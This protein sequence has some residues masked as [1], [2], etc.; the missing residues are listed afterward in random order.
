MYE[1]KYSGYDDNDRNKKKKKKDK[2]S[3]K[4]LGSTGAPTILDKFNGMETKS[5]VKNSI[6]KAAADLAAGMLIGPALSAAFGKFAPIAGVACS[7]GGHY[8]GDQS[9]LLRGIGMA[10]IAHSVAKTKEYR[11]PNS[12]MGNRFSE[13]KD[14]WLRFAF[15]EP[16]ETTPQIN[17]LGI[18]K[19]PVTLKPDNWEEGLKKLEQEFEV[20]E[21]Q[22]DPELDLSALDQFDTQAERYAE[23]YR[24]ENGLSME[25]EDDSDDDSEDSSIL[26]DDFDFNLM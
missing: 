13:L 21:R 9:G 8:L 18:I 1:D 5:N 11:D 6:I 10:T 7:F 16:V 2:E 25:D 24:K 19:D 4:R 3:K 22:D 12:T 15:I 17:G 26:D 20:N 14:D 23:E